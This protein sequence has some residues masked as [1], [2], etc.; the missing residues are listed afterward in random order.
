MGV[1]EEKRFLEVGERLFGKADVDKGKTGCFDIFSALLVLTAD[2]GNYFF[3]V[4]TGVCSNMVTGSF[5]V[6]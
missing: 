1:V 6:D 3:E 5:F 2:I 4:G